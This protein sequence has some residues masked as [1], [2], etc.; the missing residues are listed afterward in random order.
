M[1]GTIVGIDVHPRNA[2]RLTAN[3]SL[4][5]L[6]RLNLIILISNHLKRNTKQSSQCMTDFFSYLYASAPSSAVKDDFIMT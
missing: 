2:V 4:T 5:I 6:K 3:V 1:S